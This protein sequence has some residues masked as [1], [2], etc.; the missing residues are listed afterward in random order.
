MPHVIHWSIPSKVRETREDA[1]QV[2]EAYLHGNSNRAFSR[3]TDVVAVPSNRL[4]DIGVDSGCRKEGPEVFILRLVGCEL[5]DEP[6]NAVLG[7]WLSSWKSI[8]NRER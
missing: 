6:N 1:T 3:A 5:Y 7:Y 2:T 4:G 8:H